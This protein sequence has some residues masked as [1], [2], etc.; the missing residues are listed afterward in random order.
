MKK[1]DIKQGSVYHAK[2]GNKLTTVRVDRII[3]P[4]TRLNQK[5]TAYDVTNLATGRKTTFRSAT[6]AIQLRTRG[7][8][9]SLI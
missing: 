1:C 5:Q 3:A 7:F 9:L 8:D 6:V 4:G 2:V